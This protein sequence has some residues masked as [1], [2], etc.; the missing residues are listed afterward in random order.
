M[1]DSGETQR[2]LE[3]ALSAQQSFARFGKMDSEWRAWLIAAQA[4]ERLGKEAAANEYASR[5]V[6]RLS[7]LEQKWGSETYTTYLT[8]ADVIRFR[9]QAEQVLKF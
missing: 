9:K 6:N 8:R 5:A 2:A 3:T 1:L 4:S 7:E